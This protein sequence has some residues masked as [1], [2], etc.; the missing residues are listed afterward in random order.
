MKN[1]YWVFHVSTSRFMWIWWDHI[2]LTEGSHIIIFS[3]SDFTRQTEYSM[4]KY[5][6]S[7]RLPLSVK[8]GK[9]FCVCLNRLCAFH[10]SW[11]SWMCVQFSKM[12]SSFLLNSTPPPTSIVSHHF[13]WTNVKLFHNFFCS[14]SP[15]FISSHLYRDM[16]ASEISCENWSIKIVI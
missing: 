3:C 13:Q 7:F 10:L 12:E 1:S 5:F 4:G 15:N 6:L 8:R 16:Y 2:V 14:L 9:V 11:S